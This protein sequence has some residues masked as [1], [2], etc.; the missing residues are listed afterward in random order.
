MQW[1][2]NINISPGKLCI[3]PKRMEKDK[4]CARL[5]RKQLK[6]VH[7]LLFFKGNTER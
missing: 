6:F 7:W 3:K 4:K 5:M 2:V 1:I